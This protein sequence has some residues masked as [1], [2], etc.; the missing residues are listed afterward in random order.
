MISV[1]KLKKVIGK[2]G[3]VDWRKVAEGQRLHDTLVSQGLEGRG[4]QTLSPAYG[5]RARLLDD[6]EHDSRIVIIQRNY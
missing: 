3:N 4:R 6:R 1:K 5:R 2:R